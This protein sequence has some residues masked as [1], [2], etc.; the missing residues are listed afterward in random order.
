MPSIRSVTSRFGL[1]LAMPMNFLAAGYQC[2]R[3]RITQAESY[4][5]AIIILYS[6][7]HETR[8]IPHQTV[9]F[10][11][12]VQSR[13]IKTLGAERRTNE[14]TRLLPSLFHLGFLPVGFGFGF[15]FPAGGRSAAG[16]SLGGG[17][18]SC[19]GCVFFGALVGALVGL[20]VCS[21]VVVGSVIANPRSEYNCSQKD[22][23]ATPRF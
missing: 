13:G 8:G 22:P 9:T 18:S 16:I 21:R 23:T 6:C 3:P 1:H 19:L 5:V 14:I 2:Y 11:R 4:G 17:R 10:Y 7:P 15:G 12:T 20:L